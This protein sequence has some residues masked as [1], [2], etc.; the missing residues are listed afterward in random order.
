M[1]YFIFNS[2]TGLFGN[3]IIYDIIIRHNVNDTFISSY[4]LMWTV[5]YYIPVLTLALIFKLVNYSEIFVYRYFVLYT[6]CIVCV[7]WTYFYGLVDLFAINYL[8]CSVVESE[9]SF[10]ELLLNLLNRYHPYLFYLCAGYFIYYNYLLY[11]LNS[12]KLTNIIVINRFRGLNYSYHA[13]LLTSFVFLYLGA[14]WANQEGS[15]GGWW[16]SDSSEM[17]GLLLGLIPLVHIHSSQVWH[18]F[19]SSYRSSVKL[20]INFTWLYYF[21]QIN[22]ELSSHNF[23]LQSFV[24]FNNNIMFTFIII[25]VFI[26]RITSN[27]D[28]YCKLSIYKYFNVYTIY[29]WDKYFTHSLNIL[30]TFLI[31]W[32]L[33]SVLPLL[34]TLGIPRSYLF[35]TTISR[36]Y[37]LFLLYV[38]L[39]AANMFFRVSKLFIITSF[40]LILLQV[41]VSTYLVLTYGYT[42]L[43]LKTLHWGLL[44]VLALNIVTGD[45]LFFFIHDSPTYSNTFWVD[46]LY[47]STNLIFINE[48]CVTNYVQAVVNSNT[49]LFKSW[50]SAFMSNSNDIDEFKLLFNNLTIINFINVVNDYFKSMIIVE[51]NEVYL[52]NLIILLMMMIACIVWVDVTTR[53]LY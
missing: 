2:S 23:G 37:D 43:R 48:G 29:K 13:L 22:Y 51:F 39:Y 41:P 36:F 7:V 49:Q 42:R 35:E 17:L 9:P 14:W 46:S 44:V 27:V 24:F 50:T 40:A 33:M 10:N 25:L 4:Y 31:T 34:T 3:S 12:D 11:V 47:T 6:L 53:I 5:L 19:Y 52:L 26:I 30:S 8:L 16:N 21:L 38:Y 45:Y 15:W 32:I 20:F 18:K 28:V 1:I